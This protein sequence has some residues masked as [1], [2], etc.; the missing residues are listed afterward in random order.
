VQLAAGIANSLSEH[1]LDVEMDVFASCGERKAALSDLAANLGQRCH[2]L[3]S[4]VG[5]DDAAGGKLKIRLLLDRLSLEAF[6]NDG[7]VSITNFVRQTT[8]AYEIKALSGDVEFD[9]LKL[10]KIGSMWK[11]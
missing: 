11:N 3:L 10:R 4:L 5:G 1:R 6:V 2:D 9:S 8:R 7:E